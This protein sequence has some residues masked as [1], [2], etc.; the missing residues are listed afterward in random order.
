[1]MCD[2]VYMNRSAGDGVCDDLYD[3]YNG[4]ICDGGCVMVD[5]MVECVMVDVM[6]DV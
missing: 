3:R 6:V 2:D 4:W 1:M 5:V